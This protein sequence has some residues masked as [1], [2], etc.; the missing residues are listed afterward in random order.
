MARTLD[1]ALAAL[2]EEK[3]KELEKR[4]QER[5]D[6][7]RTLQDLR[8]AR[9]LT[10]E[11]V[12]EIL[13]VNQEN[14]SRME[15]RSDLLLSTLRDYITAM[16]GDLEIIARFPDRKPAVLT[17]IFASEDGGEDKPKRAG[18]R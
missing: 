5:L 12:A 17:S 1:E 15:R 11:K 9:D 10:Q 8:K 14:V 2:P 16:G 13:G 3:R 6:E 7:Y 18:N 4:G